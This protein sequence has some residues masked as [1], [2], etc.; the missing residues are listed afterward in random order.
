MTEAL[1]R[2]EFLRTSLLSLPALGLAGKKSWAFAPQ[3]RGRI[4][5]ATVSIHARPSDESAILYQRTR[6]EVINLYGEVISDESPK[7]N[8]LWYKV[9]RGYIHCARVQVVDERINQPLEEIAEGGQLG[10]LSVPVSYPLYKRNEGWQMLYPLYYQSVHWITGLMPGPDGS[11]WYQ[12]TEAW[13]KDKYY[14]PAAHI[15]IIPAEEISPLSTDVPPER[16]KVEVSI[17]RQVLSAYENGKQ[18]FSCTISSGLNREKEGEIPWRTPLGD[19]V[20]T[21]KMPSQRMGDDPITSDISGYVLPGVPWVCYFHPTGVATHGTYWHDNYG[22]PMSHGCVNMRPEDSLWLYRW[23]N[24][25]PKPGLRET[26]GNGTRI[27]VVA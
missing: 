25:A 11:P 1:S 5:I 7:Y 6:D 24:P 20:I 18:V 19:F 16:K 2:R 26:V 15:R 22:V 17:T 4:T 13:S 3:K 9:W 10:Q 21:S 14:L 8:P 27:N 23:S 12:I